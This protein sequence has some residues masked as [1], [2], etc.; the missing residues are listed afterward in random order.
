MEIVYFSNEFPKDD[1]QHLY[2][3]FQN[4][5][6][7]SDHTILARFIQEATSA[8]KDEVR[9]LP[10]ELKQQ[11]PPF[12]T[13]L[14]WADR[15]DLREGPLSGAVDGVLLVIAQIAAYIG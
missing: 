9:R 11:I 5:A 6:K 10:T 7:N 3:N 13:L 8:I 4:H 2:R 14:S 12:E 15:N 1:L